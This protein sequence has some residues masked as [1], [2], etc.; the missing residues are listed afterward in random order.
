MT[1]SEGNGIRGSGT[2]RVDIRVVRDPIAFIAQ[3][4]LRQRSIC[5]GLDVLARQDQ[6]DLAQAEAILCHTRDELP[7]H[8]LDE[9]EDF[10]PL[11]R[12]RAAPEDEIEKTLSRLADDHARGEE[13]A[14]QAVKVLES[15]ID[16]ATP[17]TEADAA[18]LTNYAAHERLH[19]IVENAIILPLA[20]VRLNK[21]DREK[22]ASRMAARRG[23][24]LD[25]EDPD[26]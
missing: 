24:S 21:S 13:L 20:R 17:L 14:M 18:V 25:P 12:R 1:L 5:A 8:V 3:E 22:L 16:G 26:A 7:V 15:L 23:L 11:L 19:L 10:F 4:H 9:E 2:S 6:P